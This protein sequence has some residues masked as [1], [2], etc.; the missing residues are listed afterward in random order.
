MLSTIPALPWATAFMS[1]ASVIETPREPEALAQQPV[2]DRARDRARQRAVTGDGR[3]RDVG[4]HDHAGAG[5]KC[6][7]EGCQLPRLED[8]HPGLHHAEAVMGVGLHGPEAR[9]VL[10]RRHDAAGHE[11][12]DERCR[13]TA[14][15]GGSDPKTRVPRLTLA[16]VRAR[17]QTGA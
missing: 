14:H 16:G 5:P 8:L 11:P 13:L 3:Q 2:H 17:S 15:G 6:R 7:P 9:E 10:G 1:M 4:R 12:A